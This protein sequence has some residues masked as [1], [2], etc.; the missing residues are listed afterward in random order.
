MFSRKVPWHAETKS[1]K[2]SQ[3]FPNFLGF[4][5]NV[6]YHPYDIKSIQFQSNK[7]MLMSQK[8]SSYSFISTS[9]KEKHGVWKYDML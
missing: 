3:I 2:S 8:E 4:V 6:S 5:P 7:A 1:P 9:E